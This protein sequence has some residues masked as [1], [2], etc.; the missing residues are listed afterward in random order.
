MNLVLAIGIL[1]ITGFSGGLLARKIKFP[2][3]SGYIIIGV[4]LSPSLL[5]VIPSELIRGELSVV[6]DI[7]LGIIAYLI[8]GSL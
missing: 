4:L 1:I 3:I 7:T 6:T 8:G 2:R 5:N